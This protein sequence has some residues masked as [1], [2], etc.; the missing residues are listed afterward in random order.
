MRKLLLLIPMIIIIGCGLFGTKDFFPIA[1]G[2]RWVYSGYT[3]V[4]T[5]TTLT[6]TKIVL[7]TAKN[8]N[9]YTVMDSTTTHNVLLDTNTTTVTTAYIKETDD[10][11]LSYADTTAAADTMLK[12]PLEANKT[13]IANTLTWKVKEQVDVTVTA[14]DYKK[15]WKIEA[16][17][18]IGD[19]ISI[20]Q[21]WFADGAGLVKQYVVTTDTTG[22]DSLFVNM[23]LKAKPTIK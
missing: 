7:V 4:D 9:F 23:E 22:P 19:T 2:N 13:W 3:K 15:A 8:G 11:I 6:S 18:T 20:Y 10:A 16:T 12:L 5:T 17:K 21:Q 14:G 1:V